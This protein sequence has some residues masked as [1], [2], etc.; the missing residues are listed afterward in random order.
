MAKNGRAVKES[1][2]DAPYD[3]EVLKMADHERGRRQRI[4]ACEQTLAQALEKYRCRVSVREF[5]QD[6]QPVKI[7]VGFVPLD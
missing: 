3:P 4:L 1:P 5:R 7:E 6:G 2:Q